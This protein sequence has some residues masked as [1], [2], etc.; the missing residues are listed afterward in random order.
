MAYIVKET[1]EITLVQGDSIDIV[2]NGLP[3][4][5]NYKL[6]FAAQDGER[7]P[8]GSEIVIDTFRNSS[9]TIRLLGDYTNN[10]I[11][12]EDRKSQVYYYGLKLCTEDGNVED[13]LLLGNSSIGGL[14]T[15]TVYP[16]KVEGV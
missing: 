11:V 15:I 10:F 16:K 14:N 6:Y 9:A 12:D 5:Q 3:T 2:V 8:V 7:N 1:G 13:T 4:D